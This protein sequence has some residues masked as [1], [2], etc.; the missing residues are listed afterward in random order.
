MEDDEGLD[1]AGEESRPN[2]IWFRLPI[3]VS[4]P[5]RKEQNLLVSLSVLTVLSFVFGAY[6]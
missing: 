6:C 2:N 3:H 5:F 1:S 4:L